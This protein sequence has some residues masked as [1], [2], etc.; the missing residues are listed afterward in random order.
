ME[1]VKQGRCSV[2]FCDQYVTIKYN[3]QKCENLIDF[4][5]CDLQKGENVSPCAV[6][7]LVAS[8]QEFM[9][10]RQ[11]KKEIIYS[12][13]C[14]Y[15]L[16]YSLVNEIIHQCIVDNSRGFAIHAA[17]IGTERG[18]VL[19]PGTSGSGKSTLTTFL[20]SNGCNYLTDELVVL[21]PENH[22]I[23]P[24]TRPFCIKSDGVGVL[25]T[26]LTFDSSEVI[27][28]SGGIMLPHRLVNRL[29]SACTPPLSMI[30]FPVYQKGATV[31]LTK[32][33]SALGCAKL[34]KCYVNARNIQ[35]HGISGL[36]E[37]TRNTPIYRLNYGNFDGLYALLRKSFPHLF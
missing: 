16:A 32:L 24:L 3:D 17:A 27:K 6:Y 22:R 7:N 1:T 35:D 19:L 4:L 5:C 15:E 34:I 11:Q 20:V 28:G 14:R 23:L 37:I 12:G 25:S 18:G 8:G 36:A 21:T 13:K 26:F 31:E 10:S 2:G 30:L 33:S 29:F 9:L